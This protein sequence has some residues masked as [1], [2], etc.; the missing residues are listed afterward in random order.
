MLVLGPGSNCDICF[1]RFGQDHKAPCS[2][3]CGHV[4]CVSCI[5]QVKTLCPL[6]RLPFDKHS[7]ITL[8]VDS[9][10]VADEQSRAT[11][12]ETHEAL[13]LQQAIASVADEGT[14]EPR[15]R[16]LIQECKTFLNGKPR[17]MHK[18][19]RVAHRMIAYLCEVRS[20]LRNTTHNLE[21]QTE[22]LRKQEEE[23]QQLVAQKEGLQKQLAELEESQ[24]YERERS[25]AVEMNLRQHCEGAQ[26]AYQSLVE[27]YN[28]VAK[29]NDHL[30]KQ[31]EAA[32]TTRSGDASSQPPAYSSL[33]CVPDKKIHDRLS[34]RGAA[35]PNPD[36]PF[37]ISPLPQ[38]TTPLT[39]T[40]NILALS[41]AL[42]PPLPELTDDLEDEDDEAADSEHEAATPVVVQQQL[43]GSN[44]LKREPVLQQPSFRRT[45][46]RSD[47][48][49]VLSYT[50]SYR[51]HRRAR[52]GSTPIMPTS[53]THSPLSANRSADMS[54]AIPPSPPK[55][56]TLSQPQPVQHASSSR[57][58]DGPLPSRSSL[59]QNQDGGV[60][61]TRLHDLLRDSAM[62]SSLP[63]MSASHFP[64]SFANR[65]TSSDRV[66]PPP[67]RSDP[68][69]TNKAPLPSTSSSSDIT[70]P[71]P[72]TSAN[73]PTSGV[74]S[75]CNSA[76]R[77]GFSSA[78]TEA[79]KL[80]EERRRKMREERQ[81][82][83]LEKSANDN[84]D[85]E[86]HMSKQLHQLP[87][88]H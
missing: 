30:N 32:C 25:H 69:S 56:A 64:P 59:P 21:N 85:R 46:G 33:P 45:D 41:S 19:L 78:S 47:P 51:D 16:Q 82:P 80:E 42:V 86:V 27:M 50:G 7:C 29:R 48:E 10:L 28:A 83:Q 72:Q 74:M 68:S 55:S 39:T 11:P 15:L 53:R 75:N 71:L 49:S 61:R 23:I 52:S 17:H 38:F 84:M 8:R 70:G 77:Q 13:R 73:K 35:L 9:D 36:Y 6:C 18:E 2:I 43:Q 37:L 66:S 67:P 26:I 81:Q 44:G 24:K 60:L 65:E 3:T 57:D 58:A 40:S 34:L 79:K 88:I 1:E 63:N 14:T 4:F 12:T 76:P 20:T 5:G 54:S 31:L 22:E 87:L 62:S